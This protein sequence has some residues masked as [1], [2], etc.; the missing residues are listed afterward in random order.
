MRKYL[1]DKDT[2]YDV[3]NIC[4]EFPVIKFAINLS[5]S[6]QSI[7]VQKQPPVVFFRPA[8]LSKE[9]PTQAFSCEHCKIFKNTYFEKHLQTAASNSGY[10]LHKKLSKI[11]QE[12]DWPSV[13]FSD[14][15][16]LYFTYFHSLSLA[17]I[18]CHSLSFFATR[19]HLLYS[20]SFIVTRCHS[21]YHSSAFLQTVVFSCVYSFS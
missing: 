16:S 6:Q 21:L 3:E 1:H 20:L 9:T 17:V 7:N 2:K 14:I 10:I 12:P 4:H 5:S 18:C 15:N 19:C 13:S 11:I 8:I